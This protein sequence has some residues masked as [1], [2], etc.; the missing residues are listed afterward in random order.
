MKAED[1]LLGARVRL[2]EIELFYFSFSTR[3]LF[4]IFVVFLGRMADE[5]ALLWSFI[6][7]TVD[8]VAEFV[9]REISAKQT[10]CFC[11]VFM[12]FYAKI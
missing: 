1:D 10:F 12:L 4:L 7:A 5:T 9:L 6:S 3:F 8:S 2:T 11:F